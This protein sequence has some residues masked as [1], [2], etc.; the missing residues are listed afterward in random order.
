VALD[1]FTPVR[2]GCVNGCSRQ[3]RQFKTIPE[4]WAELRDAHDGQ[5]RRP[6]PSVVEQGD[7]L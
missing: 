3:N 7:G 5:R 4:D 6:A 2:S 1:H